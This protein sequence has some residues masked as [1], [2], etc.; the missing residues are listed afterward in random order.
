[1]T[2]AT[3]LAPVVTHAQLPGGREDCAGARAA[4]AILAILRV[5][6]CRQPRPCAAARALL[7]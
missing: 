1:M 6:P 4:S 5:G 3:Q 2:T 7:S